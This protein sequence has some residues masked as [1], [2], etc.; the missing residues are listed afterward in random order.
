MQ[1][2]RAQIAL[3]DCRYPSE[4]RIIRLGDTTKTKP[5]RLLIIANP[6]LLQHPLEGGTQY[7]AD[8][9]LSNKA[10]FDAA[11]TY[12]NQC[13]FGEQITPAADGTNVTQSEQLLKDP[14]FNGK[15]RVESL[16]I[17]Q[18]ELTAEHALVEEM[19]ASTIINPLQENFDGLARFFGVAADVIFA[20]TQSGTH[21]RASAHPTT[22]DTATGG[23]PFTL[24]G[25][26]LTHWYG[27]LVPG[28]VA[29]HSS[30]S[31]L[32]ALHE[33]SHAASSDSDGFV[34]DLYVN[35]P[36]VIG[37]TV[38]FRTGR[39]IPA[40]FASLNNTPFASDTARDGLGYPADWTSYHCQLNDASRPALMDNYK[41]AAQLSEQ[42]QCRHDQITRQFLLDRL[43]AKTQRP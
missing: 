2:A 30:A 31:T 1:L 43:L 3:R 16:F 6:V 25:N 27:N 18:L 5:Y 13:L 4:H 8:P 33:F 19:P 32:T 14:A 40:N 10:G 29:I 35:N 7:V 36:S 24:D 41:N 12:I 15:I 11:V 17:N 9:I 20:V 22:D 21:N 28:V 26:N 39:P 38:N 34:T 42:I 23:V 37:N